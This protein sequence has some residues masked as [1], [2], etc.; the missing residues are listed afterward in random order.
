MSRQPAERT[1]LVAFDRDGVINALVMGEAG[2]RAPWT[3]QEVTLL[4]GSREAI[5]AAAAGGYRI[6]VVT[7]QPDVARG[8]V[9]EEIVH[10]INDFIGS[11]VPAIDEFVVCPHDNRDRC[12]CRKPQPG[13]LLA[14][15][16]QFGADPATSWMVGDRWTDIAAGKA[17]G[18]KTVLV[19]DEFSVP[20]RST[21]SQFKD[22]AADVVV[23][24]V[25]G[26]VTAILGYDCA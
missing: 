8:L 4:S 13:M 23:D 5:A 10:E 19:C 12:A 9:E 16:A 7:N 22:L 11:Q 18:F 3:L 1:S 17:A 24:S 15:A 6:A 14:A 21:D 2:P 20:S 25:V 26:A